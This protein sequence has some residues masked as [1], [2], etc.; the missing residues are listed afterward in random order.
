M[1]ALCRGHTRDVLLRAAVLGTGTQA[2]ATTAMLIFMM[3]RAR[4]MMEERRQAKAAS[5]TADLRDAKGAWMEKS[6]R[7][8]P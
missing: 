4:E 7:Q 5:G 1:T 8:E 3:L 2:L 6:G